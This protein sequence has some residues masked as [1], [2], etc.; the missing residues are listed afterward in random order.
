[1]SAILFMTSFNRDRGGGGGHG[2]PLPRPGSAAASGLQ[3]MLI[4]CFKSQVLPMFPMMFMFM[5]MMSTT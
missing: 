2:P 4:F 5:P 3:F 1:M